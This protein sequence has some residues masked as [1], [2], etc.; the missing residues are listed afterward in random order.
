M[1][2]RD[3]S[4]KNLAKTIKTK[5]RELG[6]PIDGASFEAILAA[7]RYSHYLELKDNAGSHGNSSTVFTNSS[8]K[9]PDSD[10]RC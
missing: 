2:I 9:K 5:M 3:D 1:E 6:F 4:V 7:A 8:V 10:F